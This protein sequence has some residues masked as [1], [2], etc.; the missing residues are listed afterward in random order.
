MQTKATTP[1][2]QLQQQTASLHTDGVVAAVAVEVMMAVEVM[3]AVGS[4]VEEAEA[5][6]KERKKAVNCTHYYRVGTAYW[7]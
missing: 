7:Q 2:P 4:M 5:E 3:V 6:K 1:Q